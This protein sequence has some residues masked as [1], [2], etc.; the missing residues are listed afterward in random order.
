MDLI[1]SSTKKETDRKKGKMKAIR[2]R[3]TFERKERT[4][5]NRGRKEADESWIDGLKR[6]V[7][8][9]CLITMG[10]WT[11]VVQRLVG[12]ESEGYGMPSVYSILLGMG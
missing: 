7:V 1:S 3:T 5:K 12:C 9:V 4:L 8:G 10:C 6:I 11:M 2:E